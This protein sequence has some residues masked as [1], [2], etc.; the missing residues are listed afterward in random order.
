MNVKHISVLLQVSLAVI[1]VRHHM[2]KT[3]HIMRGIHLVVNVNTEWGRMFTNEDQTLC[4]L[5][6]LTIQAAVIEIA[7]VVVRMG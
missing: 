1:T 7:A 2:C 6:L 4:I 5:L 3:Y